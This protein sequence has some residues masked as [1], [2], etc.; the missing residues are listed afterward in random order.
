MENK[1]GLAERTFEDMITRSL[2]SAQHSQCHGGALNGNDI[3][4]LLEY[5]EWVL[6]TLK[7]LTT[8]D[9][10]MCKELSEI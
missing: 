3:E 8:R 1:R 9:E 5:M 10:N 4:R 7:S 6:S 2:I